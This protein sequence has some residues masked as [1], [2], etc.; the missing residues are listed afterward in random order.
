MNLIKKRLKKYGKDLRE[1]NQKINVS[2]SESQVL[3]L[4][5]GERTKSKDL[6]SD[7]TLHIVL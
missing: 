1:L 2:K 5:E 7:K 4:Q 3:K 6:V